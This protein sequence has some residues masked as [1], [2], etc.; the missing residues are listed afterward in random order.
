MTLHWHLQLGTL[1]VAL[2]SSGAASA[3]NTLVRTPESTLSR[4]AGGTADGSPQVSAKHPLSDILAWAEEALEKA[5][6]IEDYTCTF[7]KRER[8]GG[9]L[10]PHEQIFL[11]V[12][13]H[14]FSVYMR[15]DG[16]ASL[17]GQ[18]VIFVDGQNDAKLLAIGAGFRGRAAGTLRL[19]PEGHMAMLGNR[20]PITEVGFV[21]MIERLINIGRR[22]T[23]YGECEVKEF[24]QAKVAGQA[25]TCVQVV[26]PVPRRQF[27]FHVARV[28]IDHRLGLPMRFEAYAWPEKTGGSPVLLEEYTLSDVKL[29]AGLSDW[30]FSPD[31]PSY[32]FH[33]AFASGE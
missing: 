26:H 4:R 15:F 10:L 29:N 24:R 28:Y 1:L 11:K 25:C 5:R 18:E 21:R 14:P 17:R 23:Q 32:R 19:H 7:W 20:Y 30:D 8:V 13:H 9:E 6:D 3:E 27:L 12:R 2:A 22:D 33:T 31:N 16:P